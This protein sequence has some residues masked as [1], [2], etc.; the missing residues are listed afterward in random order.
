LEIDPEKA[1]ALYNRACYSSLLGRKGAVAS[2]L[3]RAFALRPKLRELAAQDHDLD[4]VRNDL[5]IKEIL[6]NPGTERGH[7]TGL[8]GEAEG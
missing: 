3:K 5:E 2:D 7:Q 4:G 1:E 8:G 6:E